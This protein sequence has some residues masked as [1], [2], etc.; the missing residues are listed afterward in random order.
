MNGEE[1]EDI[2]NEILV[3]L[4][5]IENDS[6]LNSTQKQMDNTIKRFKKFLID[7]GLST[8]FENIAIRIMDNYLQYF[9]SEL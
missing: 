2:S 8:D 6:I 5:T 7:K 9:F 4:K 3:D 1:N